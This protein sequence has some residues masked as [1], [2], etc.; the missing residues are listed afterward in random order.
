MITYQLSEN[1]P[2]WWWNVIC[3]KENLQNHLPPPLHLLTCSSPAH[4]QF[5]CCEQVWYNEVIG[6]AYTGELQ[7]STWYHLD[8]TLVSYWYHPDTV[9]TLYR[10]SGGGHLLLRLLIGK[11][12]HTRLDSTTS[13]SDQYCLCQIGSG[14]NS[15]FG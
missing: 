10:T 14:R 6:G 1:T 13:I 15:E 12:T 3:Y 8:I 7:A 5:T 11:K 4:L 9:K 2:V